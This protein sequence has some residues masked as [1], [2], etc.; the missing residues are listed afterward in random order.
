MT[1]DCV[2]T[3][4]DRDIVSPIDPHEFALLTSYEDLLRRQQGLLDTLG[5][6]ISDMLAEPSE[7]D[8][9]IELAAGYEGLVNKQAELL[10]NFEQLIRKAME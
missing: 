10:Q 2:L 5:A 9:A 7:R 1:A 4:S 8:R 6:V 3:V